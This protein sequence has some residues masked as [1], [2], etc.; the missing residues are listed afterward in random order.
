MS[1]EVKTENVEVCGLYTLVKGRGFTR[2]TSV[3]R[4]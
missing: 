1:A 3:E 2:D 4:E